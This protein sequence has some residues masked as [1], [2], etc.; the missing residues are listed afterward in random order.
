MKN[1]K[2]KTFEIVQGDAFK[3]I[4][5]YVED[6]RTFD[7]II[8]DPPYNISKDNNF[9]TMTSSKRQGVDFGQWDKEFDLVSWI[10]P[11]A[12]LLKPGGTF[13]V[14]NSYRNFSPIIEALEFS[15][16]QVKDVIRWVKSNPMP[17]NITRRY[18]QDT[19]YAIWAVRPG[20]P[21][22]FNRP[23]G[24]KILRAQFNSSTVSGH[25]RTAHPT[26]KSLKV[27][28]EIIAIHTN[29]GDSI[30]DP[31]M[32]SGTTG[33]AAIEMGRTFGGVELERKYFEIAKERLMGAKDE[34]K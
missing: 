15:G 28:K 11:A 3:V 22:V 17:R 4:N 31:F 27:L 29:K 26:Q 18:V 12:K 5:H 6:K 23:P 19:E 14:F 32:G 9:S 21:W 30:F 7:H 2:Q 16:L 13:M 20:Q 1:F 33:V 25:E 8:T 10:G 34:S 24:E